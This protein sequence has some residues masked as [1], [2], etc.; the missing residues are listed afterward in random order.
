MHPDRD[1]LKVLSI[2]H[3]ILGGLSALFVLVPVTHLFFGI[4]LLTGIWPPDSPPP[5]PES[6]AGWILVVW[7]SFLMAASLTFAGLVTYAAVSLANEKRHSYCVAI[8]C[9]E[10]VLFPLGTVLGIA[11]LVVLFRPSVK[12]LFGVAPAPPPEPAAVA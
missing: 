7:A 10:C 1:H 4:S 12:E 3:F 9:L 5:G 6:W 8:A 11:T 2:F